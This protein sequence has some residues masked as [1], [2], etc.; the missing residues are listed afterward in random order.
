MWL[1]PFTCP[2]PPMCMVGSPF[3][4]PL[5]SWLGRAAAL[6]PTDHTAISPFRELKQPTARCKNKN[7]FW[8]GWLSALL[9]VPV[10]TKAR[11]QGNW[12][13]WWF[14]ELSRTLKLPLEH[15]LAAE[16]DHS[17]TCSASR[18]AETDAR[19]QMCRELSC[20]VAAYT[21]VAR[22]SAGLQMF[23]QPGTKSQV[24]V[25]PGN[26]KQA[27]GRRT[28]PNHISVEEHIF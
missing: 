7:S 24:R 12:I 16:L 13:C 2:W 18:R 21:S 11:D 3:P 27:A 4:S 9:T 6:L 28:W 1:S 10:S 19:K 5:R 14:D 8:L 26:T 15:D 22:C 23:H 20:C 17:K 25:S